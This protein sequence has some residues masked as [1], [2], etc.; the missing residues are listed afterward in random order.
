MTQ[1][2]IDKLATAICDKTVI[3]HKEVLTLDEATRYTGLTKSYLYK[4]TASRLIPHFK[5]NGKVIYFSRE[6]LNQ[7]MMDNPVA[8]V[9]DINSQVHSYLAKTKHA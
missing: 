5:P 7:W 4:L 3:C 8:T 2:E 9:T 1:E 6:A